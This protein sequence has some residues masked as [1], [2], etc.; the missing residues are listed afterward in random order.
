MEPSES[1][2]PWPFEVSNGYGRI[3]T[4]G[5][6]VRLNTITCEAWYGP[7]PTGQMALHSCRNK[8]CWAGEHLRWGTAQENMDDRTKDGTMLM[9]DSHPTHRLTT[10]E[11]LAIRERHASGTTMYRLSKDYGCTLQ[12]ISRIIHR[13]TWKHI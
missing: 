6:E 2:R 12:N 10:A 5:G 7:R 13:E 4:P 9:G 8:S 11:V 3:R 1:C